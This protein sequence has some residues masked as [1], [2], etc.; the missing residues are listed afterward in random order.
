MRSLLLVLPI[1]LLSIGA[2]ATTPQDG[3][4]TKHSR[5][6][7]S[8]PNRPTGFYSGSTL[9]AKVVALTFDDGPGPY[10]G[11]VLDTLKAEKIHATFFVNTHGLQ[12]SDGLNKAEHT[13][14]IKRIVKEGHAI[15]NHTSHH[16]NLGEMSTAEV[17]SELDANEKEVGAM[18]GDGRRLTLI[19]PP[20][21][22][23]W[24][25]GGLPGSEGVVGSEMRSRGLNVLWTIDSGDSADWAPGEWYAKTACDTNTTYCY[26]PTDPGFATKVQLLHDNV[27]G[28]L[29]GDGGIVLMHD[30]HPCSRDALDSIIVDLRAKGYSFVTVEE[31]VQQ[32]YS[33]SS[34]TMV[35]NRDLTECPASGFY[36]GNNG[37]PGDTDTLYEC[38][39]HTLSLVQVCAS[40][41][42]ANPPTTDDAC[43]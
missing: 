42:V 14:L 30:T 17:D 12:G 11:E 7:L 32:K 15:G 22:S 16:N 41:C 29:N 38:R 20:F 1:A 40:G 24:M 8:D 28:A 3:G 25:G 10:T 13:K 43:N 39:N 34:A 37:V 6:A 9:P 19:R 33:R 21:G 26:D 23:P 27:V 31:M 35:A 36:C 4:P 5:G 18:I 2:C